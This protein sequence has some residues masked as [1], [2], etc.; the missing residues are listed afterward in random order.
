LSPFIV[1]WRQLYLLLCLY[2]QA[3]SSGKFHSDHLENGFFNKGRRNNSAGIEA[4][5]ERRKAE[6]KNKI[7]DKIRDFIASEDGKVSVKAPL[8]VGVATGSVL[9]SQAVVAP[10]HNGWKCNVD[11]H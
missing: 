6:I 11:A 9:F 4:P 5:A 8:T 1:K 10:A 2:S 7:R 3:F